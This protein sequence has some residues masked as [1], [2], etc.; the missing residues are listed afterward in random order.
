MPPRRLSMKTKLTY[1]SPAV[2]ALPLL[3]GL[4]TTGCGPD[5]DSDNAEEAGE[6]VDDAVD[7][8]GDKADDAAEDV[9]DKTEDVGDKAEDAVD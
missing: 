5:K 7:E 3:F 2:L 6:K 9:G 8:A 4:P 1:L